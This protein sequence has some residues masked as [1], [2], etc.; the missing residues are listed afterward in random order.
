M[1]VAQVIGNVV[2]TT[3]CENLTGLTLLL[4]QQIDLLTMKPIGA[5]SVIVD[6]VGAGAGEVVMVVTGGSAR[7]T[8]KTTGKA[9][10]GSVIG[11]IDTVEIDGKVL[12]QKYPASHEQP[13]ATGP[14]TTP[15]S[16]DREKH[17]G[18]AR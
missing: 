5:P 8:E 16:S 3:K 17:R 2:S 9:V 18:K 14:V 10:D 13:E 11:I 7:L 1:Y 12:F 4:T 6:T 15:K